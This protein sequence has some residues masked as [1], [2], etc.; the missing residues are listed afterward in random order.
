VERRGRRLNHEVQIRGRA[1]VSRCRP[2]FEDLQVGLAGRALGLC[3]LRLETRPG[4][5]RVPR[6]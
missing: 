5:W 1:G 6:R 2:N 3:A 4:L